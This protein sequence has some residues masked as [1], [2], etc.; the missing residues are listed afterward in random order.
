VCPRSL[1]FTGDPP[2]DELLASDPLALLIGM[3]LD[4]RVPMEKAF[5][6]PY[7]LKE[8]MGGRLDAAEIAS[9]D[10]EELAALFKGPPALHRYPGSMAGRTQ[11]MCRALVER[12]D[13]DAASVWTSAASGKEL[14]ANLKSLPGFGEQKARIFT[15]LLAKRLGV[16]PPGWE[17][18]AGPYA[19]VGHYSVADIDGPE[20]LALV[21][22]HKK[23]MKAAAKA[24]R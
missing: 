10:A 11:E 19:Q 24:A 3:L 20:S 7:D 1:L 22:A 17:E 5:R 9:T 6:G 2:A 8:R 18:V 23:A 21:R 12:Y 15:A 16:T 13:G 14:F 4:Q